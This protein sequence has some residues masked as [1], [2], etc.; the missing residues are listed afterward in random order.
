MDGWMYYTGLARHGIDRKALY[1]AKAGG[2]NHDIHIS[3]HNVGMQLIGVVCAAN[4]T[5]IH[6][7]LKLPVIATTTLELTKHPFPSNVCLLLLLFC[8]YMTDGV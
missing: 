4:G 7:F 2:M 1:E 3:L 8:K 5:R 6:V